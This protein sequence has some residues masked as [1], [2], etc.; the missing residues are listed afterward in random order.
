MMDKRKKSYAI[1]MTYTIPSEEKDKAQAAIAIFDNIIDLLSDNNEHLD[2]IYTPFKD[3]P[4]I[5]PDQVYKVRA[6]LRRYRDTVANNF[7]KVKR[8]S[9]KG[10][11]AMQPFSSDTQIIKLM[12]S[13]VLA[14]NDIEK[15][16]NRFILLF[17]DLESKDFVQSIIKGSENIKKEIAQVKQ[18][19]E[20]RI[21]NH[22]YTNIL[23]RNWVD[24]VSDE[25]QEKV[26]KKIPLSVE[27][28]N[29]RQE[30]LEGPGQN[31]Q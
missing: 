15:Q 29:Q 6:A 23:A 31:K 30:K 27:L 4:E 10:F 26:E 12:K 13:F 18:I 19:I 9:F 24:N 7:N 22:I 8:L 1:G 2:L 3:H 16:V 14:I 5:T 20:D 21:K 25:L 28:V 11:V 17:S